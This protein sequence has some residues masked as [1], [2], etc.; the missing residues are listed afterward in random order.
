MKKLFVILTVLSFSYA[1]YSQTW[2]EHGMN[3]LNY[4]V[5]PPNA[6][7]N[8]DDYSEPTDDGWRKGFTGI[9][10]VDWPQTRLQVHSNGAGAEAAVA[11]YIGSLG[12]SYSDFTTVFSNGGATGQAF[13]VSNLSLTSRSSVNTG[14]NLGV[15]GVAQG[16]GMLTNIGTSGYAMG[17]NLINDLQGTQGIAEGNDNDRNVGVYGISYGENL[18]QGNFGVR[19]EVHSGTDANSVNVGVYG[20]GVNTSQDNEPALVNIGVHGFVEC[21]PTGGGSQFNCGVYGQQ[22]GC[23]GGTGGGAGYPVG[24]YAAFFDGDVYCTGSYL[25]SDMNL[26]E[27]IRPLQSITERLAQ[28]N[29]YSYNFKQGTG[30][31][32]RGGTQFGVLSQ[33]LEKQF[34]EMVRDLNV[35]MHK[36]GSQSYRDIKSI[37]GVDYVSFIPLLIQS[38]KELNEKIETLDPEKSAAVLADLKK[39]VADIQGALSQTTETD[40][41]ATD[42]IVAYPNPSSTDMTISIKRNTACSNCVLVVSDLAGKSIKQYRVD[43]NNQDVTLTAK[44]FGSGVFQCSLV[45]NGKVVSG[46]RIAFTE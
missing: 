7:A 22:G 37:K 20:R 4:G 25:P 32:L 19:G 29:I 17:N 45:T 26:K 41:G 3:G 13:A 30:L 1:G 38:V 39:K 8:P 33:E 5:N 34:P 15:A 10:T 42:F 27:N 14:I 16:D 43:G 24:S 21:L 46:V 35:I 44:E 23:T 28:V 36:D 2:L 6:P 40:E 9:G 11:T 18:V 12:A 31:S